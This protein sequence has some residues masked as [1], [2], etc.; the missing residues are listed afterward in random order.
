MTNIRFRRK[1]LGSQR[2]P[3]QRSWLGLDSIKSETIG[4]VE[5][6]GRRC[7]LRRNKAGQRR[8]MLRIVNSARRYSTKSNDFVS[9]A[10]T[11]SRADFVAKSFLYSTESKPGVFNFVETP[12]ERSS[13][14]VLASLTHRLS[15]CL[16]L[17][18]FDFV[19]RRIRQSR[20]IKRRLWLSTKSNL[21]K[22]NWT[23]KIFIAISFW[24]ILD[25]NQGPHPYQGCA[26]TNWANSPS[27]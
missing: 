15:T 24:A 20:R 8:G 27:R 19:E 9:F 13:P 4:V 23:S 17:V 2:L 6:V 5:E 1:W 11:V 18:V 14:G 3:G 25:S 16:I 12:E 26:L 7:R 10:E 22:A 21:Q